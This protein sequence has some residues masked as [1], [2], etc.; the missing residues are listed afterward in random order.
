M[1]V[2]EDQV[3]MPNGKDGLYGY[4]DFRGDSVF[5]VPVDDE[6]DTY[7]IQQER[8][9]TKMTNW[10]IPAGGT[11]GQ[12]YEDAAKR[13][14]LEEAS[15]KASSIKV[16]N[17]FYLAN[18]IASF[19]GAICLAT[20]LEKTTQQLDETDGILAVRKIPLTKVRDMILGGEIT[21]GPTITAV[22]TVMAY[23]DN[24]SIKN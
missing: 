5:I 16:I 24:Q 10:E 13:E 14:L 2:H 3:I 8:Y 21:D 20:D 11:D 19:K 4:I 1:V 15:V 22:L 9:V 6:G 18:G 17:E 23:L 7:L 12:S